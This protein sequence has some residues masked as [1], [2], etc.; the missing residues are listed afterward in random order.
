MST[1]LRLSGL[2]SVFLF[3]LA[4]GVAGQTLKADY[5]F[6]S[7]RSSSIAGAPASADLIDPAHAC[8]SF[9]N[10]FA[11]DTIDGA[12]RSI[13]TFPQNNGLALQPTTSV[14]SSPGVYSVAVLFRMDSTAGFK[15]IMDFLGGTSD[16]GLYVQGGLTFFNA[17]PDVGSIAPGAWTQVVLTR[18]ASNV[19]TGYLNGTQVWQF[20]DSSNLALIDAH[21][22]LRFFQ[23]NTGG[24]SNGEASAGAVARIRVWDGVLT[25]SQVAALDRAAAIAVPA[26]AGLVAWWTADG[27]AL[28]SR[29]RND[30]TLQG[31]TFAPGEAGQ[32]F[33]LDGNSHSVTISVDGSSLNFGAGDVSVEAWVRSTGGTGTRIIYENGFSGTNSTRLLETVTDHAEFYVR[34]QNGNEALSDST[35]TINDS[36]WHHLAGVRQGTTVT[37]FVDGVAQTPGSNASLG[38]VNSNC[39]TRFIGGTTTG[40]FCAINAS[41][42]F[43][44]GQIDE[45][46]LYNRALSSSEVGSIFGAG[47]A[48]KLKPTA[49]FPPTGLVGW[50]AGDGDARDITGNGSN[51]ALGLT[52]F[53]VGKVG[54]AFQFNDNSPSGAVG[55]Q[56]PNN[57][58]LNPQTLTI[59]SWF[60]ATPA[61]SQQCIVCRSDANHDLGYDLVINRLDDPAN[62][63][64]VLRLIL[65]TGNAA[66]RGD[67]EDTGHRV[68]DGNLHHV[69]ATYDGATMKIYLDGALDAQLSY[70]GGIVYTTDPLF[71]GGDGTNP[72][73]QSFTGLID[74][75]S[76]YNRALT[77]PEVQSIFNAGLA[78]KLKTANTVGAPPPIASG[79]ASSRVAKRGR[80]QFGAAFG[81]TPVSSPSATAST[82]VTVGDATVTFPSVTTGGFTQEIPIDGTQLPTPP[83]SN[84]IGLYYDVATTAVFTG[85][86]T[87]C[88][89]IASVTN[90]PPFAMLRIKHFENGVWV[91]RTD[92]ASINPGAQTLCTTGLP[93]LSPF[94]IVANVPTAA[95]VSVG[96]RV[97]TSSGGG[98]R[99]ATVMMT[100]ANGRTRT[101]VS[102]AFG[103]Y[104]FDHVPSGQMYTFVIGARHYT[105][106]PR[107]VNLNDQLANLDFVALY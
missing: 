89:H 1:W 104:S 15:R 8:P 56:V 78:G 24:T 48:G 18:D 25:A 95:A 77:A 58:I 106:G 3:V 65:R 32:A 2:V 61:G 93:S 101:A 46:A 83:N 64:G 100:D 43:F 22:T 71:I 21:N 68:I 86:P 72:N 23:D 47:T 10:G 70:G 51:G 60:T 45:L 79:I 76:L 66:V 30:G 55:V 39:P 9:C 41:E 42:S 96:G 98:L 57:P 28:D 34:D 75:A 69:A 53:Q 16:T 38:V 99:G 54:Q 87:V 11:T 59:E 20:T 67:L 29:G 49:T 63:F 50:W 74:E 17:S 105:F 92:L 82:T 73:V 7:S 36:N 97:L 37:L 19:V 81:A 91:D 103:Y 31:A 88:F 12:S 33:D 26:P 27:N 52:T 14:L 40:S 80:N 13:L 44:M 35:N 102:N 85:S 5:R 107:V 94:A 84:P 62:G 4:A 6:Q 90:S